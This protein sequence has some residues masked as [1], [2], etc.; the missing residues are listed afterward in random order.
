MVHGKHLSFQLINDK[1]RIWPHLLMKTTRVIKSVIWIGYILLHF[2]NKGTHK[3]KYLVLF[4]RD[5]SFTSPVVDFLGH[6]NLYSSFA[7]I[8]IAPAGITPSY[9]CDFN[10]VKTIKFSFLNLTI[11]KRINWHQPPFFLQSHTFILQYF[12][13]L[14]H[15]RNME[16]PI[17][18]L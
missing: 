6:H 17:Q 13:I 1:C 12:L 10:Q 8:F 2:Q 5:Y 7:P 15:L 4:R 14:P 18:C 11:I 3:G 9:T 16:I